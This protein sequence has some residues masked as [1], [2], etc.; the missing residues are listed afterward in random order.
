MSFFLGGDF[1]ERTF[2][3]CSHIPMEHTTEPGK[4][5]RRAKYTDSVHLGHTVRE[6]SE[7]DREND[8]M[9]SCLPAH[10][11]APHK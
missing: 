2:G 5:R 11:A 9:V 4:Y 6:S 7:L 8:K 1:L 3:A 10:A